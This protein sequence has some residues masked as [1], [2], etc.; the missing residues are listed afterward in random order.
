MGNSAFLDY[1]SNYYKV[2]QNHGNDYFISNVISIQG[3]RTK[4]EDG[5]CFEKF[6]NDKDVYCFG[7]FDGHTGFEA[8]EYISKNFYNFFTKPIK[9]VLDVYP[10]K[11]PENF[12]KNKKYS[13][14]RNEKTDVFKLLDSNEKIIEKFCEFD[15]QLYQETETITG[16]TATVVFL[17]YFNKEIEIICA[18]AGDSRA[19]FS[20]HGKLIALSNDHKP[21]KDSEKKRIEFTGDFIT[22]D[23]APRVNGHLAVSRGFGDFELKKKKDLPYMEQSVSCKPEIRRYS[24]KI[25]FNNEEAKFISNSEINNDVIPEKELQTK[26]VKFSPYQ[27]IIVG[28]DGLYDCFKSEDIIEFVNKKFDEVDIFSNKKYIVPK[29]FLKEKEDSDNPFF[30]PINKWTLKMKENFSK[31]FSINNFVDE[32]SFMEQIFKKKQDYFCKEFYNVKKTIK[33]RQKEEL[34]NFEEKLNFVNDCLIQEAIARGSSDNITSNIILLKPEKDEIDSFLKNN[35]NKIPIIT[36]MDNK[37]NE[38]ENKEVENK[39]EQNNKIIDNLDNDD[40]I[41]IDI[42]E[43]KG[44]KKEPR[45]IPIKTKRDKL[46]LEKQKLTQG[47]KKKRKIQ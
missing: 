13:L 44:G 39:I 36:Q 18:N 23:D 24:V 19:I 45:Y 28:C 11:I 5:Y 42:Q 16:T 27:F 40:V 20:N 34:I 15:K 47:K 7:V 38:V 3:K 35:N 32:T 46:N 4:S 8:A 33:I 43:Q 17:K 30:F 10:T 22:Y 29:T 41:I 31:S 2:N 14:E 26:K 21:N 9:N 1:T 12:D 6:S 37:E 25:T